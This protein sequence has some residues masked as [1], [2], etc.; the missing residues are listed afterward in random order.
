LDWINLTHESVLWWELPNTI[1]FVVNLPV[2]QKVGN[3]LSREQ[4]TASQ[5]GLYS[6]QL[7]S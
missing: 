6:I 5:E 4:R 7:L 1:A 3:Y 2:A